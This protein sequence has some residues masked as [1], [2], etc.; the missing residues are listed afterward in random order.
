MSTQI[1]TYTRSCAEIQKHFTLLKEAISPIQLD[2]LEG[3]SSSVSLF[4]RKFVP[5]VEPPSTGLFSKT[6]DMYRNT[7]SAVDV[8]TLGR[9]TAKS[10][11]VESLGTKIH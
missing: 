11:C 4:F 1:S 10:L 3:R 9:R 6:H 7:L 8:P 5:F 2:E